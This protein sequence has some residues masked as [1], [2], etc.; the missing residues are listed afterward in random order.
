MVRLEANHREEIEALRCEWDKE[1][2][3]KLA[4]TRGELEFTV[5]QQHR[6]LQEKELALQQSELKATAAEQKAREKRM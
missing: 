3:L 1:L 5:G 4:R 6:S 2:E